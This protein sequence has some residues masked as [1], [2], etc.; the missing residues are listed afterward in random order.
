MDHKTSLQE[1]VAVERT[2]SVTILNWV[3]HKTLELTFIFPF[4]CS[5]SS[6]I[7]L[8]WLIIWHFISCI[9]TICLE[10]YNFIII[11]HS[12]ITNTNIACCWEETNACNCNLKAV[13]DE[14]LDNLQRNR[15]SSY[16]T[17]Y[18]RTVIKQPINYQLQISYT[19]SH[20]NFFIQSDSWSTSVN[21]NAELG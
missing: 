9:F 15:L 5:A 6:I 12:I 11:Y 2:I 1:N 3:K 19:F 13:W 8:M 20:I 14:T 21:D 4:I 17:V 18:V 10:C 7:I 16:S